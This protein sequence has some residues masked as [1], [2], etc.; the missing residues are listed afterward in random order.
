M[1]PLESLIGQPFF[2]NYSQNLINHNRVLNNIVNTTIF[3][4][5][6]SLGIYDF[7]N[8][9]RLTTGYPVTLNGNHE[10]SLFITPTSTIYSKID[11]MIKNERLEMLSLI[12]G[13][14]AAIMVLVLFLIRM[15]RILDKNIKERT[16]ELQESNNSLLLANKKL[17]SINEQIQSHDRMQRV[18]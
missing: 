15:N 7:L 13:I 10:Y 4:D 14:I 3:S 6:P 17:E 11:S 8:G 2:G 9:Q 5:I 18:Y 12:V 16:E 1:H